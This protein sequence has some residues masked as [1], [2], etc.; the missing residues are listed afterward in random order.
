M[1]T[2]ITHF[3]NEEYMLPWWL[4]HHT[5]LF[6][7]GILINYASTDNSVAIC[8]ELA[9]HWQVVDSFNEKFD[10]LLVDFE[11]MHYE[12]QISG[13]K[14]ALNVSEFLWAVDI[15]RLEQAAEATNFQGVVIPAAVMVDV[16]PEQLPRHDIDLITQKYH[17]IL[18]RELDFS[19]VRLPGYPGPLRARLYHR[20][21]IGGYLAGRHQT[22]LPQVGFVQEGIHVLWYAYSPWN[23]TYIQR[24]LSFAPKI[25]L[26]DRQVGRGAQHLS[27]RSEL[28]KQHQSLLP[29]TKKL[30]FLR[31]CS[32]SPQT[33]QS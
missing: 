17:G 7:H 19:K 33:G 24:K 22:Q 20:A 18:E 25:P 8:R 9:P 12:R 14:I 15:V 16:H 4:R 31:T 3:Y 29:Y 6:D 2:V 28:Q 21:P 26:T 32:H 10:A 27:N 5:R 23:E 13:W 1:R 30:P 11:V